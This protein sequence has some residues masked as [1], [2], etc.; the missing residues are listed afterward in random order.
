MIPKKL[1]NELID[2]DVYIYIK[3][4]SEK[5]SGTLTRITEDDL[6]VLKDKYNNS[7][8]IPIS[9]IDVLTERR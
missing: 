3:N 5:F 9:E 6:V 7:T 2:V 4:I 8:Y 1:L